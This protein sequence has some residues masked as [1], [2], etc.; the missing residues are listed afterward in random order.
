MVGG[1]GVGDSW[2]WWYT[3]SE[4]SGG[5]IGMGGAEKA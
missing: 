3:R 2:G 5:G 4:L 1:G